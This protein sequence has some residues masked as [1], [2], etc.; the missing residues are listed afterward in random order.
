MVSYFLEATGNQGRGGGHDRVLKREKFFPDEYGWCSHL[1]PKGRNDFSINLMLENMVVSNYSF[2]VKHLI[3]LL[4]VLLI[5]NSTR[6]THLSDLFWE[7]LHETVFQVFSNIHF[8][9]KKFF[10]SERP[11]M[12]MLLAYTFQADGNT[13][14]SYNKIMWNHKTAIIASSFRLTPKNERNFRFST[15]R[16]LSIDTYDDFWIKPHSYSPVLLFLPFS[17]YEQN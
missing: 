15:F 12:K 2:A 3:F 9:L 8:S 7:N 16:Y 14:Y 13:K 11:Q 5:T 6:L 4:L 1:V 17:F 10:F